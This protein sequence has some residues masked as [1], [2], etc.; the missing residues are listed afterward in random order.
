MAESD[1]MVGHEPFPLGGISRG[2][3]LIGIIWISATA[4]AL[5]VVAFRIVRNTFKGGGK[6]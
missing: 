4:I 2:D 5:A 3:L 1:A 6:L